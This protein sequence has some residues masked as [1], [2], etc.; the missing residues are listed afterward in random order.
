[1]PIFT[2]GPGDDTLTGSADDDVLDGRGGRDHMTGGDGNDRFV[3]DNAGDRVFE[4]VHQGRDRI[5]TLVEYA[6]PPEVEELRIDGHGGNT[7]IFMETNVRS[8]RSA[9][10]VD[11]PQSPLAPIVG[12][13]FM[14]VDAPGAES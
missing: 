1:M 12:S 8:F 13:W 2:G 3:I 11:E 14:H 4:M 5:R 7:A 10:A 6:L 9:R